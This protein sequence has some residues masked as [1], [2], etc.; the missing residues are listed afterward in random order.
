MSRIMVSILATYY[1]NYEYV[2]EGIQ[3]ILNQDCDFEYEIILGDDG[4]NDGT[5]EKLEKWCEAYPNIMSLHVMERDNDKQ[6]LGPVRASRNRL[7]LLQYVRGK[8]F[9]YFDGD[10]YYIDS[11]KLR[12]QV[13]I[14]ERHPE[15]VACGHRVRVMGRDSVESYIPPKIKPFKKPLWT[16]WIHEYLHTN[17]LMFRSEYKSRVDMNVLNDFFNDN[18]ITYSMIQSG[19]V[20]Y[21]PKTMSV[22]RWT[23]QGIY[24]NSSDVV[25]HLREIMSFDIELRINKSM[26]LISC[27]RHKKHLLFFSDYYNNKQ[28]PV[29]EDETMKKW[30]DLII[31]NDMAL[32]IDC[33][34]CALSGVMSRRLRRYMTLAMIMNALCNTLLFLVE[35]K[36]ASKT[37]ANA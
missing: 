5:R 33:Y 14:M 22:Y 9:M 18:C 32:T 13:E 7:N 35:S 8:Y 6:Y 31:N 34:N 16:Y 37:A 17:S 2:D 29:V 36:S 21:F 26:W 20:F 11:G 25:K 24:T 15:Y 30:K 1:N 28:V 12:E 27:F 10:D 3:S 4:S 19:K 23:G